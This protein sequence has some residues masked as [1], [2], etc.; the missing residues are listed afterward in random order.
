MTSLSGD[1]T[2]EAKES[3]EHAC[4]SRGVQPRHFHADN[5]QFAEE[6]FTRDCKSKMQKFTFVELV[7]TTKIVLQIIQSSNSL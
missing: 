3:L 6:T 4:A 1:E 5:G 7:F 2:L